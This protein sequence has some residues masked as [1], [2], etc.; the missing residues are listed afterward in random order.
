MTYEK[1]MELFIC[2]CCGERTLS[3]LD[4]YEICA[5][6]NW[7]DDP[8]QSSSPDFEGGANSMSLNQARAAWRDKVNKK[9]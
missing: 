3:E 9:T 6:C 8:V 7:E 5:V 2:P 4:G 1:S